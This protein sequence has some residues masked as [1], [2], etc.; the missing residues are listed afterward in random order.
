[1][2][3]TGTDEGVAEHYGD[4]LGEECN[5]LCGVGMLDDSHWRPDVSRR[6]QRNSG[7]RLLP[8]TNLPRVAGYRP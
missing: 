8:V 2:P 1:V 7:R 4:P 6:G 5:A 3:A